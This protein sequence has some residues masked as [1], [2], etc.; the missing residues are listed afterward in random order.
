MGDD[1]V[2]NDKRLVSVIPSD[3]QVRFQ[4]T[5]FY[6]FVHFTANTFTDREWGDGTESPDIFAP[7]KLDAEQWVK[8]VVSAAVRYLQMRPTLYGTPQRSIL[9]SVPDGSGTKAGMT[10]CVLSM[11]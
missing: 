3:R 7:K 5:E 1:N 6:A 4:Q 10:R 9:L 2:N 8:A 11:S